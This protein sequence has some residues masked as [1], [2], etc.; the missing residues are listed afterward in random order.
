MATWLY[1]IGEAAARRAWAVIL[2]W[3][4]IIAGVASA[5]T[6]FHGKLSNTF[7]MPGT[8]TQ[9]LSDELAQRFPS[10][11]RG[12]GQII[13]TTG[14]GAALTEEQKQAFSIAL[15]KLTS[16]V[17][18][19]DAVTDP[20]TTTSKLAEAKTQL[21]E[22]HAKIDA[23]P[24]QIEEGKKQLSTAASQ[25]EEGTKQIAESEKKLDDSQAQITSG[26]EQLTS[27][28]KQLDDAQAQLKSGYTQAEAAGSPADTMEQLNT[29]QAQLAEQQNALNQQ[30]DTLAESQKQVDAGRAEIASKKEELAEGQK[31]LDKQRDQ[32]QKT[33]SELPAQREQL[34]RQQKLYDFAVGY[35]MVSEDQS[36]AIATVSFKKKIFEVPSAD[37]QKVMSDIESANLHGAIVHFDA[38]LSESALGGGSHTGE[39]AGMVIAFIVL[40]IMLGTFVAAG[41]PILMSLVGV[42]VGVLGTLSLSSVIQ[43]SSTAYTLGLMLG[44]AVGIDYSLFILNRYRTNLLEGMPKNRAIAL[45]NGTSGNAVIFAASTVIIALVA[46]NVTGIPFLGVMG[47]AAAFCVVVAALIAVTLTPAVLSLAGTKVMPKKLW[48]SIDTPKKIEERRAQDAERTEKPNGWL[49]LVLARP[50]LT[51]ITGTLALLAVAAPMSQMRLG[52]PDASNY[53]SDSA[54]YKSYA[55]IKDKFG[56][57]MSAPLVAVAHTPADMSEEQVQQAQID[58]ASALKEHGGA[59]VQAVVPGGMTDNRT[60]MIFQVIP[61]HSASSVETEELV[62]ELR[63]V[64]VPVQGSEVSLGIAGQTSGNID[65]SEVL[66]QKL[67]LYLG[68]VMGLSFLVLI[69]VFRSIMV[70]LV[71]SVGFLFSVLASFG[72]VVAIYQLGFMSSLFGVDHPGPVLSFLPT[73]LIGILFG[74]AMDYQMFLVTGMRE[75]YVHGKDAVTAIVSG[76]NHAVRVVVAAAI[77]MISV[78]GGF[79]FADSTMIRPMG[80]GLAFGVLVDACIVRM[81]LTPAIMALLGDKAWWMPK[82]LDRLTPNMD[83]EGAAL[84]EKMR[85]KIQYER[86][87]TFDGSG[88]R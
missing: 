24:S 16:E 38:N 21:D 3:V 54:A 43:M 42:V 18:S 76:Y 86:E 17:P 52:L 49:R 69:L 65:V 77:I 58:I 1:R 57:G 88:N 40:M 2:I 34:E 20:F 47:N 22:A 27:A 41:L 87:S 83:V 25:V 46:L 51:L 33:E 44:L 12:S 74:L 55:L 68:V 84:S 29:Q 64:T 9:Q 45:A 8:Q 13:L 82:W 28:Q 81:T 78:F 26:Q 79:I 67:P 73:L 36:T 30:R 59:N 71:A 75:A 10:A 85:E 37:L 32:L 39:V 4:F 6:T 7:T 60:L 70:P 31:K 66:A 50:L 48:A 80:F 5:Y 61:A 35:R 53:P 62:H 15:K 11:N 19:V 23:A 14:N 63:A 56:E 72:A